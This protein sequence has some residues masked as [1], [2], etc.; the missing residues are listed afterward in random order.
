MIE[1]LK[2]E[3]LPGMIDFD[4]RNTL[5]EISNYSKTDVSLKMTSITTNGVLRKR[6][7][8]TVQVAQAFERS[9][10]ARTCHKRQDVS[11]Y[12]C[13]SPRVPLYVS[14]FQFSVMFRP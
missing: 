13:A 7:K 2:K 9:R 8:K 10:V 6:G 14:D 1:T 3:L 12:F 5:E 11:H 4:L